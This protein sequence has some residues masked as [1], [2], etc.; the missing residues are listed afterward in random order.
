[1]DLLVAPFKGDTEDPAL[2][3]AATYAYL[4]RGTRTAIKSAQVRSRFVSFSR[5]LRSRARAPRDGIY[6][7][8]FFFVNADSGPHSRSF[9]GSFRARAE[10]EG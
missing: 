1:M 4:P 8:F 3:L 6:R 10:G 2:M 7:N 5:R 9:Q